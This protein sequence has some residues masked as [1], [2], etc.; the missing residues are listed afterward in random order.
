MDSHKICLISREDREIVYSNAIESLITS[1]IKSRLANHFRTLE[2]GEQIRLYKH[3]SKVPGSRATAG[4]FFEAA[5]QRCLQHGVTFHLVP[6]VRLPSR[7]RNSRWHT[8]HVTRRWNDHVNRLW[9]R[10][11]RL[12]FRMTLKL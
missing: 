8:S 5:G 10:D 6:M 12:S 4:M 3:F 1:T 9:N 7:K 2:H 11:N